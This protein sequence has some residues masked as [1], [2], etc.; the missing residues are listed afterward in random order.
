MPNSKTKPKR[1][2]KRQRHRSRLRA[3][4]PL[5]LIAGGL[6]LFMAVPRF[7]SALVQLPGNYVPQRLERAEKVSD[8]ALSKLS[9]T[10][11]G[12]LK[13][14]SSG[15]Q[16]VELGL[17]QLRQAER[18]EANREILLRGA[19]ADLR[20]G[21]GMKPANS[22]G[23]LWLAEAELLRGGPSPAVADAIEMS[24]RTAP[25]DRRYY[26]KRLEISLLSWTKLDLDARQVVV[27]QVHYA[28]RKFPRL[29]AGLARKA[30]YRNLVQRIL[31]NAP[32]G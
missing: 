32:A 25:L 2:L 16:W 27:D 21:L 4:P 31:G 23:W 30:S 17:V 26:M 13:W 1:K 19:V 12:S 7:M 15:Q 10:R 6:L 20:K 11:R 5:A 8:A 28:R 9:S 18:N 24:I 3:C 29:L 22:P 14:I